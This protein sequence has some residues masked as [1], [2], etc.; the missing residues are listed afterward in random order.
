MNVYSI[1]VGVFLEVVAG[2]QGELGD[3]DLE[4]PPLLTNPACL[5]LIQNCISIFR[6]S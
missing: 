6:F 2:I 3:L 5:S 4:P 1:P